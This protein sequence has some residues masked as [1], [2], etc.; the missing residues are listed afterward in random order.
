VDMSS[1]LFSFLGIGPQETRK[2]TIIVRQGNS[3]EVGQGETVSVNV[4]FEYLGLDHHCVEAYLDRAFGTVAVREIPCGE[5]SIAGMAPPNTPV[6]LI[7]NGRKIATRADA[8]G[9]FSFR[10]PNIKPGAHT[11]V[12]GKAQQVLNYQGIP[13]RNL[14]LRGR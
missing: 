8:Q 9:R 6:T 11:L 10:S 12:I 13:I 14:D 1:G 7:V 4:H 5:E 2:D 3:Q